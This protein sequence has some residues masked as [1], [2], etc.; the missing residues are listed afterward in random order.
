MA[1][2]RWLSVSGMIKP[3]HQVASGQSAHSPYPAGTLVLQAPIFQSL[4]LDLSPYFLGTLNVSIAPH[5]FNLLQADY[6]F[7]LVQWIEGY[8]PET[9]SFVTCKLKFHNNWYDSLVYYPH[10]ETKINHFQD[11]SILEII[12]PL[13]DG[14][15]YGE[16]VMVKIPER[17]IA[18]L[19]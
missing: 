18:I 15:E 14:I 3:G 5:R 9:F 16:R 19:D 7:P 10:P 1:T 6:R 8:D 12:A 13:I 11:P 4:G 2:D 17:A